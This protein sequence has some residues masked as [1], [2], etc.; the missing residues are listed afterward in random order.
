MFLIDCE[1]LNARVFKTLNQNLKKYKAFLRDLAKEW[2][3]ERTQQH[4]DDPVPSTSDTSRRN[5][6]PEIL[7]KRLKE[8]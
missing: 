6:P 4:Q 7:S 3:S 1:L 8:T 5:N 2:I